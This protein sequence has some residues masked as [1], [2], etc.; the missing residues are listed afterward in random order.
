[1]ILLALVGALAS[2]FF[3][4][5][6]VFRPACARLHHLQLRHNKRYGAH[7]VAGYGKAR[8]RGQL[9]PRRLSEQTRPVAP[10]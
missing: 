5:R 9:S 6:A 2:S 10:R 4:A 8:R 1:M 7:L 3:G